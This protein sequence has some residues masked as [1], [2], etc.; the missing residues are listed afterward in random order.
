MFVYQRV[1]IIAVR[2]D[3]VWT[4]LIVVFSCD[5][6]NPHFNIKGE[7]KWYS[8]PLTKAPWNMYEAGQTIW[9]NRPKKHKSD[10]RANTMPKADLSDCLLYPSMVPFPYILFT[11]IYIVFHSWSQFQKWDRLEYLDRNLLSNSF[12][13]YHSYQFSFLVG[14]GL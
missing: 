12:F 11:F 10:L 5:G 2:I 3:H 6:L 9:V 7:S 1:S 14:N 13:L 8:T 4:S